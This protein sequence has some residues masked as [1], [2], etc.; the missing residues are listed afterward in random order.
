[1]SPFLTRLQIKEKLLSLDRLTT[2][3]FDQYGEGRQFFV[4]F[5][6]FADDISENVGP[7]EFAWAQDQI[8]EILAKHG[9]D[10]RQDYAFREG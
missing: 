6:G 5:T 4:K 8:D 3:L 9:I 1:M 10:P 2:G 7:N